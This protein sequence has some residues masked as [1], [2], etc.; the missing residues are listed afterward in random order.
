MRR[1]TPSTVIATLALVAATSGTA[2]AAGEI[3]TSS[4]QIAT[5][6]INTGHIRGETINNIDMRDPQLKLR[7]N[8]DGTRAGVG[9][10]T[11]TRVAT[12]VYDVTFNQA[13]L[14]GGNT[15]TTDTV[16]NENCA[17]NVTSR[18]NL[19]DTFG[20]FAAAFRVQTTGP[21][22]VRITAN[23]IDVD[24]LIDTGFDVTASC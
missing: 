2:L 7:V 8:K 12:G 18:A 14:N 5:D 20:A 11:S 16:V 9:D 21:N 10:G 13:T 15:A 23:D 6:V 4:N 17:I 1:I 19:N 22:S 24:R 3:I